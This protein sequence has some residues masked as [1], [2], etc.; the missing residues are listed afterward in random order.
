MKLTDAKYKWFALALL[1]VIYFLL[2]GTRQIYNVVLPQVQ[3]DFGI[4]DA[5][6]L[7]VIAM[8]FKIAYG[9]VV[10]FAGVLADVFSRKWMIV[11]GVLLFSVG[12]FISGFADGLWMLLAMYG[13]LAAVGQCFVPTS[14]TSLIAQLHPKTRATALSIYQTAL[15][16]GVVGCSVISG[17]LAGLGPGAWRKA[18]W[19]FGAFGLVMLIGLVFFLRDTPPVASPSA[20]SDKKVSAL[21]AILSMARNPSAILLTI[22]CGMGM[23]GSNGFLTWM[24]AFMEQDLHLSSAM[25]SLHAFL[26]FYIGA[27]GGITVASRVSDRFAPT[28]KGVRMEM[29]I[30]GLACCAP[31]VWWVSQ[32]PSATMCC[33]ALTVWGFAHGTYDS[34]LFASLYDVVSPRYRAVSTGVFLCL[35]FI[36]GSFS[37]VVLGW[38]K[39]ATSMRQGFASLSAFY[40]AGAL[41]ILVARLFFLKRDYVKQE[42]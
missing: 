16:V 31:C 39:D 19:F 22:G 33:I 1:Y 4:V 37:P 32:S 5:A 10:P 24:K 17:W 3:S 40:I 14:S 20:K 2:Q 29:N 28:R 41:V 26:W 6:K 34:N 25:A 38:I 35:G 12:T 8:A 15:Y 11:A 13:I 7:G 36:L 23:Y 30:L 27:L 18:F 42:G 21:E 9:L